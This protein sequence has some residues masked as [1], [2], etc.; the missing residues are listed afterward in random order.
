MQKLFKKN[1]NKIGILGGTFDPPH[2]GHLHIS[3]IALKKLRLDG[4]IWVISKQNPLKQKP[5]FSTNIRIKLSKDIIKSQKKIFVKYLDNIIKSRNTFDLLN[6]LKKNN[7]KIKLFFLIGADNLINFHKWNKWKKIPELA[8][9]VVFARPNYST[10]AL[11]SIASKKLKKKDW[12]YIN[13]NK[14]NISSSL[15]RKF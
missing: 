8:K 4:I 13:S 11:N 3:K 12:M 5:Y 7:K 15:I 10:K 9:I 14:V 2:I 6:Y 1:Y